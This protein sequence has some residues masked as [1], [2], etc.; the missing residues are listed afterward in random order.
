MPHTPLILIVLDG[1]GY[2]EDPKYNAIAAAHKPNWERLWAYPHTLIDASAGAV[3][4]PDNQMGNSEVGHLNLGAGRIVFQE[5]TRVNR[6]IESGEFF[7]NPALTESVDAAIKHDHA[8]HVL[9]LLSPGGVHS[10]E[11]Q[12]RAMVE[13]A[14]KRGAR[15]LYVHAFLDG[16][17]TPPKSASA[18]L[19]AME[20]TLSGLG[21]G[22]IGTICG[23]Y[24]AMDRDKRWDRVQRAYDMLT[25]GQADYHAPDAQAALELAYARGETDEFVKPTLVSPADVDAARVNDGDTV[26]FMNFRSDRARQ[27]TSAF[28]DADFQGFA[29]KATPALAAFVTLTEYNPKFNVRVA[30]PPT[31]LTNTLGAYIAE[32]GLH[33]LRVAET[34]KYAHVT[35]FFNG[36]IETPYRN[37]DRILVPSPKDVPTYDLKPEMS[38][39]QVAEEI[40]KAIKGGRYDVIISNFANADMV[41]HSGNFDATVKAIEAVDAALGRILDAALTVGAEMLITADH[42]NAEEMF[43]PKTGQLH[44]AHTTNLVPCIY[45]GRPAVMAPT[46][47]LEDIAP[48]M[49]RI[50][51]LPIP[52]EMTGHPLVELQT[53]G[54]AADAKA[55][56]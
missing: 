47:A 16:R 13:L 1:W 30:F 22:R 46:G 29:R 9:G 14:A 17:D 23:R 24:Y 33:Q 3:G 25:L 38:A 54:A 45:V 43:D 4:L 26:V 42:G 19:D 55:R 53:R 44:T 20:R 56:G 35:F 28:T 48:T 18:S 49:L 40:V 6:A 39:P 52:D 2:R 8:V 27:L 31:P 5:Y 7:K 21:V 41:G 12:I 32:R 10:H 11:D 51:E 15:R 37:E 34:E 36:G 50:M